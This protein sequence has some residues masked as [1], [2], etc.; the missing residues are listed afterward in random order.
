[1]ISQNKLEKSGIFVIVFV[2]VNKLI[3]DMGIEISASHTQEEMNKI[4]KA[5]FKALYGRYVYS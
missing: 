1:M 2:R 4:L 3:L 5:Y